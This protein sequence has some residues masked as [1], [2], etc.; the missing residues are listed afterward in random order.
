MHELKMNETPADVVHSSIEPNAGN[1]SHPCP[2]SQLYAVYGRP[3]FVAVVP[4]SL[5]ATIIVVAVVVVVASIAQNLQ[6]P[7]QS[8][9]ALSRLISALSLVL[10]FFLS[11]SR[12]YAFGVTSS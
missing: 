3:L 10:C 1:E 6:S 12:H 4:I 7:Q 5:L 9:V 8:F 11:A 2:L